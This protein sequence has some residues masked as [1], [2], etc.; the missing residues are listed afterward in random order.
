MDDQ[1]LE[2]TRLIKGHVRGTLT[3]AE[4][5]HLTTLAHQNPQVR[6]L[7]D[8]FQDPDA[9]N[10]ELARLNAFQ[11]HADWH[12]IL[13]RRQRK[14]TRRWAIGLGTAATIGVF[15]LI[16]L[17]LSYTIDFGMVADPN[18]SQ[19]NDVLPGEQKATLTLADGSMIALSNT[20]AHQQIKD[21]ALLDIGEGSVTYKNNEPPASALVYHQLDVPIGGVY[22]LTLVDGTRVWIN[23]SATLRFPVAFASH[24]RRVTVVGEAFFEVAEDKERPFIVQAKNLE[25]EALGTAFNVNSHRKDG[26]VKAILTT[27]K[28]RVSD[29]QHSEVMLPGTGVVLSN[30]GMDIATAD[31][32]E[33]LAWKEGYFYFNQKSMEEILAEMARWYDVDVHIKNPLADKKYVGGIKRSS[34]LAAVCKLLTELSGNEFSIEGKKMIVQ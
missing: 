18:Y 16:G 29:G 33:A 21:G 19:G 2:L 4:Q 22:E 26:S 13:A 20:T 30:S 5:R 31:I 25:I 8:A 17:W 10:A 34:T 23:S 12:T 32:E 24:E 6:E 1:Q 28:I 15:L 27:G 7:L 14:L 9:L 11:Q 3:E